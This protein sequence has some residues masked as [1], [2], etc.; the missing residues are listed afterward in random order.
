VRVLLIVNPNSRRGRKLGAE[1]R[2]ELSRRGL[3]FAGGACADVDAIVAAGGDGT[4]ARTIRPAIEMKVPIGVV[5][6]GTFND[7]ARTLGIPLDVADACDVIASAQTRTIDVA[8][9]NGTYYVNE[10]SVGVS[11]RLTRLQKP[12]DKQRFGFL[13]IAASALQSGH[14]LRPFHAQIEYEDRRE[15]VKCVQ[16]T[17]ANSH[18][19]GGFITVEE[20]A[21]DDGRLDLY[22]VERGSIA[23]LLSLGGAMLFG[24][25][26]RVRG[27]R[28]FRSAA[29]TVSTRRGHRI[30]ADGEPAG[31]T[32]ARFEVLPKALRVFARAEELTKQAS[33]LE[34]KT[35]PPR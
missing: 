3:E 24:S 19:F 30:S 11:S 13:A 9:V 14:L 5:P 25:R 18:H 17:V 1:V 29:F 4:V 26:G 16:L 8:R 6:L 7:L 15:Q 22:C 27:V 2:T 34:A 33:D 12:V 35:F 31:R 10:A 21:I 28:A 20:A 32:P 23:E